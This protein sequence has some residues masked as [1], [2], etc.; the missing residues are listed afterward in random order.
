M[1]VLNKAPTMSVVTVK[2]KINYFVSVEYL[3]DFLNLIYEKSI[4]RYYKYSRYCYCA[5]MMISQ[6]DIAL[7]DCK[8]ETWNKLLHLNLFQTTNFDI[9]QVFKFSFMQ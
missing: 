2:K 9:W 7:V 6:N 8:L 3:I 5:I 4:Q 1:K